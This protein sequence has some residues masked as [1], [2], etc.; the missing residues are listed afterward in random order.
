MWDNIS[1][2]LADKVQKLQNRAARVITG[3]DYRMPINILLSKLGW[4]NLKESRNEQKALMTFRIGN[5]MT[6]IYLKD[7]FMGT[8]NI[9]RS[10]YNL[11][12]SRHNP[13]LPVIKT[14]YYRE[15]FC[16]LWDALPEE[17]K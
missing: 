1:D 17:I 14:E 4:S 8:C 13:A 3:A 9:A 2:R 6:S 11:R 7:I 5:D 12:T 15:Q 10:V 16:L